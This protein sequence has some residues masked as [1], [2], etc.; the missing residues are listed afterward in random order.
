MGREEDSV[1]SSQPVVAGCKASIAIGCMCLPA[2][3]RRNPGFVCCALCSKQVLLAC[4][5]H[6]FVQSG[7][8]ASKNSIEWFIA[9]ISQCGLRYVCKA[10]REF[11]DMAE[12]VFPTENSSPTPLELSNGSDMCSMSSLGNTLKP[13]SGNSYIQIN[14]ATVDCL[15]AQITDMD[16]KLEQFGKELLAQSAARSKS[17]PTLKSSYAGAVS[18][19]L[20]SVAKLA[21]EESFRQRKIENHCS[22]S[23]AIYRLPENGH[24]IK[25]LR[26]I[27][28]KLSCSCHVVSH[29]RIGHPNS[30]KTRP[31][32]V[33]LQ[34]ARRETSCYLPPA[35]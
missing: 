28:N 5:M 14:V 27:L 32:K 33:T 1:N 18:R 23:V 10:C 35:I 9:F 4:L 2:V 16:K 21:V 19:D 15:K 13:N 17:G 11:R 30:S 26:D 6:Q 29:A 7:G 20:T 34:P 22:A 8:S 24:D 12:L 3:A 25:Y 31:I